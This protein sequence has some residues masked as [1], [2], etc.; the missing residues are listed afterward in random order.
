MPFHSG[1]PLQ[2]IAARDANG[3]NRRTSIVA[4]V[5]PSPV[6]E[7]RSEIDEPGRT[8]WSETTVVTAGLARTNVVSA[9]SPQAVAA[10]SKALVAAI[11]SW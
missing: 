5:W 3:P 9:T 7:M 1:A 4:G 6:T 2:S 11:D 10:P 8:T